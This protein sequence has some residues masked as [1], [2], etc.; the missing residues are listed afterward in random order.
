MQLASVAMLRQK[1]GPARH[2]AKGKVYAIAGG[3]LNFA[4]A[5]NYLE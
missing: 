1:H 2:V 4:R 3:N 5:T